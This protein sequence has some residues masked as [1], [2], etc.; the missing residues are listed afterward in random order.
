VHKFLPQSIPLSARKE[1]SLICCVITSMIYDDQ[2]LLDEGV[3]N[4]HNLPT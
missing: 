4:A 1:S 2:E 3:R